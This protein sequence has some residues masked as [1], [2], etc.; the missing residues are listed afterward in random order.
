MN[1]KRVAATKFIPWL[2]WLKKERKKWGKEG[3]RGGGGE[4][5]GRRG[6]LS[7]ANSWVVPRIS[8]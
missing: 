5:G 6:Y 8:C 2:K 4:E 1:N 3:E 7:I